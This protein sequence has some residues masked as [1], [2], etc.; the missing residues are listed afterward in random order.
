[1]CVLVVCVRQVAPSAE[2]NKDA[3]L[4]VLRPRLE[5]LLAAKGGTDSKSGSGTDGS[6]KATTRAATTVAPVLRVLEVASGTGQHAYHMATSMAFVYWQ[7]SG[8]VCALVALVL[9]SAQ[10]WCA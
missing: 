8:A 9:P 4:G 6:T 7:P 5:A 10:A 1:M 2:R 3:I